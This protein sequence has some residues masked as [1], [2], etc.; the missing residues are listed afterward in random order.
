MKNEEKEMKSEGGH[1]AGRT[2]P[3][4]LHPS[5]LVSVVVLNWN[6]AELLLECLESLFIQRFREFEVI[7][8]DQGSRDGSVE[9]VR[10]RFGE[11]ARL[12]RNETNLGFA[13]GCN[14]GIRMS[15]GRWIALL[16]NDAVAD[17]RW[18]EEMVKA[19][20]SRPGIGMVAC[21]ILSRRE[22][23][24]IDNVGVAVY[25]DGM[26]RGR[27]RGERD[28]GLYE[29]GYE[30]FLPSGCACLLSRE[31]LL[32]TGLFD[33]DF[34]AYSE[35]TDLALRGRLLG[36]RCVFAPRAAVYHHYSSTAGKVSAFK[37]FHAE[38]NRIWILLRYLPPAYVALS[39][40]YTLARYLFLAPA[41]FKLLAARSPN[42]EKGAE[43]VTALLNA[44]LRAYRSGLA[45]IPWQWAW[46]KQWQSRR[47]MSAW[48]LSR[49]LKQYRISLAELSSWD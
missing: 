15:Q 31:M 11:R 39:P 38:R 46:R 29:E 37:V 5:P 1:S 35:D 3:F 9:A 33:R 22:R 41:A 49:W 25:P 24:R 8:V 23:D 20:K 12:L 14:V 44:L 4:T 26:N 42:T 48:T 17:P 10:R 43:G 18:L 32:E 2:S 47:R 6:R 16:N 19:G 7:V 40:A 30:V 36:W 34:F 21:R 28:A 13:E 27:G 45:R